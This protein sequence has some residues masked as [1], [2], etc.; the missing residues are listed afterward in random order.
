[1]AVQVVLRVCERDFPGVQIGGGT[2][3]NAAACPAMEREVPRPARQH[4]DAR[5][6][7]A[8]ALIENG[9][10]ANRILYA[11]LSG[12]GTH[13]MRKGMSGGHVILVAV[14]HE[15]SNQSPMHSVRE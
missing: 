3:G 1:M 13:P 14:I 9:R 4:R 2:I 7:G 12:I 10:Q 6:D 8:G 15:V 5:Q 11:L